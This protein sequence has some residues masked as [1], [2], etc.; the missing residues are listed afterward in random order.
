MS[1]ALNPD[2]ERAQEHANRYYESV[3]HMTNDVNRIAQNTGF[4]K[5]LIAQIKDFIF[6]QKHELDG[7]IKRFDPSFEMAQS[8]QRLI[9]GKNILPHDMT[10]LRH[11]E[12]ERGLMLQGYSQ[13]EAHKITS[14]KYNY[15]KEAA[16]YYDKIKENNSK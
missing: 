13:D 1:G 10:L 8:W 15:S 14:E 9:D 6:I 3:R 16:E 5:E 7:E 4:S 12:M 2:G 11:E